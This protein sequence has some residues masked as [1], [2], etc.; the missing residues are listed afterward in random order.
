MRDDIQLWRPP[1]KQ[2]R[3]V[4]NEGAPLELFVA[5]QPWSCAYGCSGTVVGQNRYHNWDCDYWQNEGR[6]ETPF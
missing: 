1:L 6:D 4:K 2:P 5:K 3:V